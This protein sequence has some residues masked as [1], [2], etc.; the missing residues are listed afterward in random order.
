[1]TRARERRERDERRETRDEREGEGEDGLS[2]HERVA[3]SQQVM[4]C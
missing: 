2:L 4:F 3:K 1:M